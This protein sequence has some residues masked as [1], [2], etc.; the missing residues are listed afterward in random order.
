[1]SLLIRTD[2]TA[3][4]LYEDYIIAGIGSS[5]H[6]YEKNTA[7]SL[8]THN[9]VLE[10]QKIYGIIPI[11]DKSKI[12][13][14]GGKQFKVI[15]R[16]NL[17]LRLF[18]FS[19]GSILCDDWLHS[20]VWTS[21]NKIALLTAHNVFQVWEVSN[22]P[23]L[24]SC[25]INKDNSILYSG[26]ITPLID[27]ILVFSGTV[28]SEVIISRCECKEPLHRLIGHK[29]VIFSVSCSIER[30]IIVTTSDDRSVRIWGLNGPALD[31]NTKAYWDS[32]T[33]SC[34]HELY[35]HLARVMRNCITNRYVISVGEDSG[36]C[37]W[38]SDG[39]L[40]KRI[41]AHQ[42]APIWSVDVD[43]HNLVTGGADCGVT[44][45]PL[46]V[47]SDYSNPDTLRI[48]EGTPKKLVYTARRNLAI[49]NETGHLIYYVIAGKTEFIHK[50][51]HE[52]T[53]VM[54]SISPCKQIIAVADMNG[55]LEV[56]V[57]NCKGPASVQNVISTKLQI[58]KILSMQWADN[59][60]LVLCSESGEIC[61]VASKGSEVE[62]VSKFLLPHCKERWLTS[63]AMHLD[64][65]LLV[66]G[67]RCGNIH[68]YKEGKTPIKTFAK[69][70]GRYGPTSIR[71]KNNEIVTTGRDGT[72]KYFT[73]NCNNGVYRIKHISS[74]DLGFQWVEKCIDSQSN[75]FCGF[76]ERVFVIT[77]LK[78]NSKLLEVPCGGGHRSWD[79]VRYIEN[80]NN[81]YEQIIKL[82]YLKNCDINMETFCLSKITSKDII[83]GT[84]PKEINCLKSYHPQLEKSMT[85]FISGGE[86]TTLRISSV[87]GTKHFQDE[88]I[89]KHLSSIR[90][91]KVFLLESDKLLVVSGGGRAQICI[92]IIHFVK[93]CDNVKVV[94]E[95]VVDFLVKGTDKERK[96]DKTWRN[97]FV[98]F[99]PETRIMDLEIV[100]NKDNCFLIYAGCSDA[101]LRIFQ[102]KYNGDKVTFEPLGQL[103]YHKTCI[104]KTHCVKFLD[105][106]ILLTC[107]TRGEVCFW[108]VTEPTSVTDNDTTVFSEP[109]LST[110]TNK[111]GINCIASKIISDSEILFATG[112]DDNAIHVKI[113]HV[114]SED[115]KS[116]K[117]VH[118]WTSDKFHSSQIT[119]VLIK[120]NTLVT[121]SI[122]QRVT[123]FKISKNGREVE[124]SYQTISDVADIHGI[125]FVKQSGATN[126]ISVFGKGI[127]VLALSL[128]EANLTTAI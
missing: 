46:T 65:N 49:L 32:V 21:D 47:A 96:G 19:P 20:G 74:K 31:R 111:S 66:V 108:D 67:D 75:L 57:E 103:K 5:L 36:I 118:N 78:N 50:I 43:E 114:P 1:M 127:E 3:V 121:A 122:D 105:R 86:D 102:F 26:L 11:K 89:I 100:E 2:V 112:G 48:G 7:K 4:I 83:K 124:Y 29:G 54:L 73:V 40:L 115:I 58:N 14:F 85:F 30:G 42:N 94:V 23:I 98:D 59:R 110:T 17:E 91:L 16:S 12:L 44:T 70:H 117:I 128:E 52:S 64:N 35:G 55:N 10:G 104:L 71:I 63:A 18:D 79:V 120:D 38:D 97:C 80:I 90:S 84:H 33:I 53:Y 88:V 15:H 87:K 51:K 109:F 119:G 56:F 60:H 116:A 126:T 24:I 61:V 95:D 99:D 62:I 77:D 113:V 81:D 41:G 72:I 93:D 9:H 82:V 101:Y 39:T 27:D 28:F 37:F 6:V 92:N 125:D 13:I 45:H 34:I 22:N 69:V 25:T 107:T 76:Q 8:E 106:I 68:C 123:V